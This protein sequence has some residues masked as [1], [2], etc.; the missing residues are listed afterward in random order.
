M[1]IIKSLYNCN[2]NGKL[3]EDITNC[4]INNESKKICKDIILECLK[5]LIKKDKILDDYWALTILE[6]KIIKL[7]EKI[8]SI[9]EELLDYDIQI[10][11]I[12]E[13]KESIQNQKNN[14]KLF[15]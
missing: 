14:N 6:E 5:D 11:N 8:E 3:E 13:L 1:D 4:Y 7:E 15:I 2:E 12:K 9:Q 10:K